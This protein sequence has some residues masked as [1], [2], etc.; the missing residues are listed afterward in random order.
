M[1]PANCGGGRGLVGGCVAGMLMEDSVD[2]GALGRKRRNFKNLSRLPSQVGLGAITGQ[3]EMGVQKKGCR[4]HCPV[5][6][7][8]AASRHTISDQE[9]ETF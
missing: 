8:T 3:V 6:N 2:W 7:D 5:K 9:F 4:P 1:L